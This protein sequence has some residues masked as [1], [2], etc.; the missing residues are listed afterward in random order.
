MRSIAIMAALCLLTCA[1]FSA[2]AAVDPAASCRA[3]PDRV[4][5]CRQIH[6]IV[7]LADGTPS[8]RIR[9]RGT[10]HLLGVVPAEHEIMPVSLKQLLAFDRDVTAELT[11]CPLS[12]PQPHTMEMVCVDHAQHLSAFDPHGQRFEIDQDPKHG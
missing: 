4:G 6:G 3:Q 7:F 11:V 9:V 1:A 5:A 10:S 12:R 8:V 2:S